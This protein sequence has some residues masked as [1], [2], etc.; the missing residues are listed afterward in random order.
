MLLWLMPDYTRD[1]T[2]R[3]FSDA[4]YRSPPLNCIKTLKA[5][6]VLANLTTYYPGASGYEVAG[7][8]WWQGSKDAYDMALAQHYE[9]NLVALI[10]ARCAFFGRNLQSRL[11]LDPTHVRLKLFHACDQWH[12]S[13]MF[14]P[15]LTGVIINHAETRKALRLLYKSPNAKFVAATLGQTLQNDTTSTDG[16]I[17]HAQEAVDGTGMVLRALSHCDIDD[18]HAFCHPDDLTHRARFIA[19]LIICYKTPIQS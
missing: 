7:F 2:V 12:S 18:N 3:L 17:L 5:S 13:R 15:Y 10:K 8:F 1:P 4:I 19:P 6:Q 11:P 9:E 16:V 14:T